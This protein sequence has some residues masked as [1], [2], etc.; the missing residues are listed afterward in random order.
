MAVA[1]KSKEVD[2]MKGEIDKLE[3]DKMDLDMMHKNQ[4]IANLVISV[5]RKN[6]TL[7]ELKNQI[8]QVALKVDRNNTTECKR[9]LLMIMNSIDSNMEGDEVLRRFEEQFDLV[10]DNFMQK[11]SQIYPSLN[12]N[13]RLMCAYL[14]MDLST[15]DIAP[16]LN[17]SI[18]GV[19]TI[20]YRLR[21]KMGLERVDNLSEYLSRITS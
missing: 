11:L 20:R 19:E 14:K 8:K 7:N 9:Q 5:A 13:E 6:E 4:E 1:E 17:M 16:L 18:R 10:N 21:K 12:Q 15:K 2:L 3:K